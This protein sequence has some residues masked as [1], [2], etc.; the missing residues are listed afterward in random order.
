[1]A[2]IAYNACY[3]VFGLS[4]KATLRLYELGVTEIAEPIDEY[5]GIGDKRRGKN[6]V[7]DR[8]E[9]LTKWRLYVAGGMSNVEFCFMHIFSPDEKFVLYVG[10]FEENR[11]DPR[12][13]QVI[14]EL[15]DAA[16]GMCAK[17][18]IEEVS[19]GTQYRID[20]YDGNETVKTRD[21][22]DWKTA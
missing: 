7:K 22:Y 11:S 14:E 12:L 20:E 18:R 15:G 6:A 1:M 4:P 8:D 10:R 19:A 17:L 13:I 5:F 2:K 16:N 9:A 3:G 21:S